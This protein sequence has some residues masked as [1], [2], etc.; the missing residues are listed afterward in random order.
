MITQQKN[1]VFGDI[2]VI[3]V[4]LMRSIE[5][6]EK[7]DAKPSNKNSHGNWS[8]GD[9]KNAIDAMKRKSAFFQF[10]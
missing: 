5:S 8:A 6:T 1:D 7:I 10:C 2:E 9:I 3:L 4:E